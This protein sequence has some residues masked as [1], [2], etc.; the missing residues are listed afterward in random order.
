MEQQKALKWATEQDVVKI[1]CVKEGE[2][3]KFIFTVGQYNV[4]PL[5]FDSQE[6]AELEVSRVSLQRQLQEAQLQREIDVEKARADAEA[7]RV[8]ALAI[9]PA[10]ITLRKLENERAMIDKWDGTMP[11]VQAGGRGD[12]SMLMLNVGDTIK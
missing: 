9:T 5:V 11:K 4:S 2:D 6:E 7:D 12:G 8:R 1:S 10:V 3:D